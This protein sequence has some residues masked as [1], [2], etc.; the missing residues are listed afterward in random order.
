M[1]LDKKFQTEDIKVMVGKCCDRGHRWMSSKTISDCVEA[2]IGAYYVGGGLVAAVQLMK[3]LGLDAEIQPSMLDEAIKTAS[4]RSYSPKATEIAILES[5]LEYEFSV[6]GLLLEAITHA[7]DEQELG[8]GYCYQVPKE[9]LS[10]FLLKV[11]C[12]CYFFKDLDHKKELV[13]SIR[14]P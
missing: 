3:W 6:K 12:F 2:L 13:M 5:K 7:S 4:L 8:L 1:P 14:K 11:F 10:N 9:V